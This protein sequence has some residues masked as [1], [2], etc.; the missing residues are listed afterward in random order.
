[1]ELDIDLAISI[2]RTDLGYR[3]IN[4]Y[5]LNSTNRTDY[6]YHQS[7]NK[8][9]EYEDKIFNTIDIINIIKQNMKESENIEPEIFY[10]G[11]SPNS[12]HSFI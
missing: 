10:R 3:T 5:L 1:M 2:W 11:G 7:N 8:I 12:Q 6:I 9:I 4:S